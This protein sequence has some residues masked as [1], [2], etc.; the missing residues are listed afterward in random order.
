MVN[1]DHRWIVL[2]CEDFLIR[3]PSIRKAIT[4][5]LMYVGFSV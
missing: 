1:K 3:T 5:T 4:M 2:D